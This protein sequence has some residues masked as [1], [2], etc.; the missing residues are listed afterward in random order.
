[1]AY[2]I[3]KYIVVPNGYVSSNSGYIKPF[4]QV[5]L[6][7]TGNANSSVQNERDYLAGHYSSANY[8]HLVGITNGAVDI[9][10]VMDTNQGAW[11]VGATV[12]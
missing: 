12:L 6:H 2:T 5:H 9:R 10:Q 1:M 7:S 3:K 11:D 8:T 4:R